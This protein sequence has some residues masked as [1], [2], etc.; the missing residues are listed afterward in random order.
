MLHYTPEFCMGESGRHER[1]EDTRMKESKSGIWGSAVPRNAL[2][3]E[4]RCGDLRS[5][6]PC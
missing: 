4:R 2:D 6:R 5:V 1:D 3:H